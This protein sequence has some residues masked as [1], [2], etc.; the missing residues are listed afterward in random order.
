MSRK[1]VRVEMLGRDVSVRP[2]PMAAL[3][4]DGDLG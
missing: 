1:L 3:D 2:D 4:D